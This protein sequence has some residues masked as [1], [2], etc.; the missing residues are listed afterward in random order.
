MPS[1]PVRVSHRLLPA[2]FVLTAVGAD[3]SGAHALARGAL[4]A[5]LPF[6]AVAAIASVSDWLDRREE[7][8]IL[9]H[10]L[11]SA[12]ILVLLVVSS[13]LRSSGSAQVSPA[14]AAALFAAAGL[15]ALKAA[16]AGPSVARAL[17]RVGPAKP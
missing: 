11:L 16:A 7:T 15:F 9:L 3:G 1:K 4:L 2:L 13:A 6:A 17:A 5:A 8:L 12:L 10:S 14:A